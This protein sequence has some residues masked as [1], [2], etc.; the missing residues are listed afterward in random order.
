MWISTNHISLAQSKRHTFLKY[1]N[2]TENFTFKDIS[3]LFQNCRYVYV[4]TLGTFDIK[5]YKRHQD[6]TLNFVQVTIFEINLLG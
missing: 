4:Y 6:G 3:I 1:F 5:V 2:I